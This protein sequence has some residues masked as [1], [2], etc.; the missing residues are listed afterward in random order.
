MKSW[1]D[2]FLYVAGGVLIICS[3]ALFRT[4]VKLLQLGGYSGLALLGGA[5]YAWILFVPLGIICVY[6]A[7][8]DRDDDGDTR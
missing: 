2:W 1:V 6:V 5:I 8:N 3:Y 4:T 7:T